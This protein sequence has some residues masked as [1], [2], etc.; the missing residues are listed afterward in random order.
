MQQ[1]C[2]VSGSAEVL[3]HLGPPAER[4]ADY[5]YHILSG[6][7]GTAG[8]GALHNDLDDQTMY[9]S[10]GAFEERISTADSR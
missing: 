2:P 4:M 1:H 3:D 9:S 10:V 7:R 6:G 5:S 8:R